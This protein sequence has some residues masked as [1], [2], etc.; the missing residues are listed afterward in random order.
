MSYL[1]FMDESG[2]D[3]RSCPYEVRGGLVMHARRL[4][5]F[6]RAMNA[7]EQ[8][9]FGTMLRD[10]G[11][12][13][14]GHSPLD[15]DR[16]RWAAQHELLDDNAR[17]R[18]CAGFLNR[19]K[20]GRPPSRLQFTAYG[21]AC[22]SMARSLFQLLRDHEVTLFASVIP[23][24]LP[25]P[26]TLEATEFLRKDHVFLLERYF[27]FL[28]RENESGLLVMDES[29]DSLDRDF[30]RRMERYFTL[31]HTGTY[32]SSRIVP[33]PFFVSSELTYP[34]QAADVSIYCIN[35][36]FRIPNGMDA[37]ARREIK[38]EFEGW[39]SDLQYRGH[40]R[41]RDGQTHY[42]HGI[43]FIPGPY[44]RRERQVP[45]PI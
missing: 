22:L 19:S 43:I 26:D 40:V 11:S 20:Q 24:D 33:S 7:L 39:L 17:R 2:H 16:F 29:E 45:M 12:E 27:N 4:W 5:P 30:V 31:T 13:I 1:L 34:I 35:W 36:G 28:E 37:P 15:R 42:S 3:H 32:R 25:R 9:S 10:Y 6:I 38:D 18:H 23:R 21:Q 14:K 41:G 44:E 8:A